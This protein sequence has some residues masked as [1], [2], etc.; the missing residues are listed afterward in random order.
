M[1]GKGGESM[2]VT[3]RNMQR[4]VPVDR[5]RVLRLVAHV[6][7]RLGME[8]AQVSVVF[9]SDVRMR[10]LNL[11]YRQ[12]D[13]PTDVL[14]FPQGVIAGGLHG[15]VLGDVVVSAETAGRQAAKRRRPLE[16]ELDLLVVHGLLHLAGMDHA[17]PL[18][19]RRKMQSWQ[20]RI[21]RGWRG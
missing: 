3:V 11:R 10:G 8:E 1:K 21:L 5:R 16:N 13:A 7:Q 4:R 15:E 20:R 18:E 17:G 9:V 19:E 6:L 2:D 14:A 12:E